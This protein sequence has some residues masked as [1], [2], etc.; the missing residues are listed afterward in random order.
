MRRC[1][2]TRRTALLDQLAE[3]QRIGLSMC[4]LAHNPT[5]ASGSGEYAAINE[6]RTRLE[7]VQ[8]VRDLATLLKDSETR[9]RNAERVNEELRDKLAATQA[10][11]E[12]VTAARDE[13]LNGWERE[14]DESDY[15][16]NAPAKASRA[17]IAEL[18][19]SGQL[20]TAG[21]VK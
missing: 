7:G 6:A 19:Q 10:A 20:R 4:R 21:R 11:L 12:D 15:P 2:H 1:K 18:W 13:A 17:R 16:D 3:S 8:D 14:I 9:A 5:T